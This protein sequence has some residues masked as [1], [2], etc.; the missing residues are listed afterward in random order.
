MKYPRLFS[1]IEINGMAVR[2][3]SVMPAI[4]TAYGNMDCTVSDRYVEF[5]AARARGGTG[6]IITE[7]CAV[8]PRGK[9]FPNE[10]GS[11]SDDFI[12]SLA[13][14]PEALHREGA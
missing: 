5:L 2:N 12:P 10:I 3:R 9:G 11:W 1:P 6:L 4:G 7:V 14:I 8:L 13:K